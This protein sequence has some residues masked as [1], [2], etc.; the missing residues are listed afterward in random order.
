M[1][2]NYL[3]RMIEDDLDTDE[4]F[5]QKAIGWALRDFSKTN[6]KWVADF[7]DNHNLSKL[8]V[9]EGSKYLS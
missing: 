3:S 1:D 9:R 6:P 2:T 4:F 7:I 8:A 5:I